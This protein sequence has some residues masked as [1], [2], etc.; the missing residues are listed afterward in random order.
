[1]VGS[2]VAV[3]QQP[4]TTPQPFSRDT[5]LNRNPF[6]DQYFQPRNPFALTSSRTMGG[7]FGITPTPAPLAPSRPIQPST[8]SVAMPPAVPAPAPA[9][10]Q[11]SQPASIENNIRTFLSQNPGMTD[12]QLAQAM[13]RY[14][15]SPEQFAMA[16]NAPLDLVQRRYNP[17]MG[18]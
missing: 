18:R 2:G 14:G 13:D 6:L 10:A 15:I 1:M 12:I 7:N 5:M 3:A 9:P 16:I 8:P 17:A 11:P 4:Q